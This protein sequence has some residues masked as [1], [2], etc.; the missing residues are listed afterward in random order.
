MTAAYAAE[1]GVMLNRTDH[2]RLPFLGENGCVVPPHLR[3]ICTVHV[4]EKHLWNDTEFADKYWELRKALC[5]AEDEADR[6]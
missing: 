4:C 1:L 3:P 5:I 2:P 6:G